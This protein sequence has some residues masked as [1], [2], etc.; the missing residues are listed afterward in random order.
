VVA[1]GYDLMKTLA[2]HGGDET[3]LAPLTMSGH[4]WVVLALGTFVS[5]LVALAVVAW[6]MSWVRTRGFAPFAIYRIALA[7]V[8]MWLL[9]RG[10]I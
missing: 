10:S 6:F 8:L 1:T 7:G 5:F 4:N 3:N 2:H 9:T